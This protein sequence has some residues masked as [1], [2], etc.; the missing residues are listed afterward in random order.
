MGSLS[1]RLS[2]DLEARLEEEVLRRNTTKTRFVQE[3][4]SRALE[5]KDPIA[6]LKQA[7]AA[8]GL[9]EPGSAGL[10]LS[11]RSE[12]VKDAVGKAVRAKRSRRAVLP[13]AAA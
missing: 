8:Y 2:P 1:L 11:V 6:L 5:P 13:G 9:P 10:V 12:H 3:L 4:L 7:R